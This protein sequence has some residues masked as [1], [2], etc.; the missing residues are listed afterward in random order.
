MLGQEAGHVFVAGADEYGEVRAVNNSTAQF[1]Y[2]FDQ[3]AK[4]GVHLRRATGYVDSWYGI[5]GQ[6]IDTGLHGFLRHDLGAIRPGVHVAMTAL[7]V[8]E[9]A[10]VDL[11]DFQARGA[12]RVE[13]ALGQRFGERLLWLVGFWFFEFTHNRV[14]RTKVVEN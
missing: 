1:V 8:A 13:I 14:R 4:V 11:H 5:R 7:L 9:L 3:P 12:K 6:D 10:D 2:A